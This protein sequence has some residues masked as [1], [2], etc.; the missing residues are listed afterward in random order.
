MNRVAEGFFLQLTPD[1]ADVLWEYLGE[2]D[3]E[4]S[5]EGIKDFLFDVIENK[6]R[7]PQVVIDEAL[8][9]KGSTLI[10]NWLKKKVGL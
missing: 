2:R 10:G 1:E 4:K 3:Y 5:G 9:Q 7:Q 6:S 8:I